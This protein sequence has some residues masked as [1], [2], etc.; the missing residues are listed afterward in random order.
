[1]E[2]MTMSKIVKRKSMALVTLA[3]FLYTAFSLALFSQEQIGNVMGFVYKKDGKK[4]VKDSV[5]I[6]QNVDRN[7]DKKRYKSEP[8]G[9]AGDY[10]IYNLPVGMY[11]AAVKIK[12]GRM[13]YPLS[14]IRIDGGRT[15]IRSF[16]L[17]PKYLLGWIWPCGIAMVASGTAV[18][19]KLTEKEEEEEVSPTLR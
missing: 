12:S 16:Y 19:L 17:V 14:V 11:K 5:V 15:S 2:G 13:F 1:M 18:I 7:V 4:P 9:D 8:T 10:R 6:L 3:A